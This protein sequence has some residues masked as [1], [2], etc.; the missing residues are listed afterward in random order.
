MSATT[1][2]AP[3]RPRVLQPIRVPAASAPFWAIRILSTTAGVTAADQVRDPF[4]PSATI[5][6]AVGLL[7]GALVAEFGTR[8]YTP[9]VFW[10]AVLLMSVVG[11]LLTGELTEVGVPS[12]LSLLALGALLALTL[13]VWSARERTLA[14]DAIVTRRRETFY[15]V[16][17]LISFAM[18]T[19]AGDLIIGG[20]DLG[21]LLSLILFAALIAVVAIARFVFR[22]DAALC[23][24]AGVILT[25]PFG[26]SLGNLLARSVKH[27]GLGWGATG[28]G[29]V[30]FGVIVAVVAWLAIS[31]ARRRSAAARASDRIEPA[32]S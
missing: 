5:L 26:A 4:G 28:T 14:L 22:A 16:A 23:F 7:A 8:R 21:H 25:G 13:A 15:W 29:V 31:T 32:S 19:A 18:G 11:T 2:T 1:M 12:W 9:G 17:L 20:F 10:L 6:I 30:F 3:D 27:G 24:W